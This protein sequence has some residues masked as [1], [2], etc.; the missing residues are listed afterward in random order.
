M[1]FKYIAND[2]LCIEKLELKSLKSGAQF[3][4]IQDYDPYAWDVT[5][6]NQ[7]WTSLTGK[8]L[9]NLLVFIFSRQKDI[10]LGE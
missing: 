1:S 9:S 2:I 6:G 4:I 10:I 7:A 8:I 5:L 3:N